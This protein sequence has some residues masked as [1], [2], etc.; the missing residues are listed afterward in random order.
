MSTETRTFEQYA[1]AA[2]KTKSAGLW[3]RSACSMMSRQEAMIR[4]ALEMVGYAALQNGIIMRL[5]NEDKTLDWDIRNHGAE[6]CSMV[7]A[8]CGREYEPE[9]S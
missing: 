8:T 9:I 7:L 3:L 5:E 2:G 4:E 6:E 1:K